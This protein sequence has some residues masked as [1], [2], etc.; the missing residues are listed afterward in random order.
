MT[1]TKKK[2]ALEILP[3]MAT[4]VE[5][6]KI[7]RLLPYGTNPWNHPAEQIDRLA[8][9][10]T[11][12][13]FNAPILV[14][15]ETIVAG[16]ARL[17]AAKRLG[18]EEVPVVPL[19]HLDENTAR[20]YRLADNRIGE[21]AELDTD[22]LEGE[23]LNLDED[24]VDVAGWNL[25]E[26][27]ELGVD[28]AL[29]EPDQVETVEVDEHKI[30]LPKQPRLRTGD[31]LA[32]GSHR[33]IVG[34]AFDSDTIARLLEGR[35][36][37]AIITDPPYAIFGS[38]TG[39]ASEVADDKMVMPFFKNVLRTISGALKEFGQAYTFTDWRSWGS[40]HNAGRATEL[41]LCN[42]LIWDKGDFG[43]GSNW[44]NCHELVGYWQKL[45]KQ[46]SHND[47]KKTGQRSI[48]LSN[49]LRHPRTRSLE[50]EGW[51]DELD[52]H[53]AAKPPTLLSRLIEAATEEGE[54][55]LDPMVGTGSTL[56]ACE[57]TGRLGLACEIEPK[58]A[59]VVVLRWEAVSGE[60]ATLIETGETLE[61]LAISREV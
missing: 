14:D 10:I 43:Q 2:N 36:A 40:F 22:L 50:S 23:L 38:S 49:I 37:D 59:E 28:V 1:K 30:E 42:L 17:T 13:G 18:L 48:Y 29:E 26:L 24:L 19:D 15:G 58:W 21:L 52:R 20:A 39:V 53:S 51:S 44:G 7:D 16:H 56:I 33:L 34:D 4:R 55:I 47:E 31:L 61:E 8:A 60:K 57:Q 12:L 41:T 32:L 9:S 11:K 27:E 6:W 5:L 45:P 25:D 46:K 3:G 54:R 35:A